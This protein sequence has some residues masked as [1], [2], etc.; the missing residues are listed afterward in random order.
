MDSGFLESLK[1]SGLGVSQSGL[2]AAF[3]KSPASTTA[4][5]YQKEF[6]GA[7]AD[8]VADGGDLWRAAKA[9]QMR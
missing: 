3:R 1:G 7:A 2:S 4:S 5:L 8:A 6:D 9:A